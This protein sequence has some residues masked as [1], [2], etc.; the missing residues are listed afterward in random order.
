LLEINKTNKINEINAKLS[1]IPKMTLFKYLKYYL[2]NE[3]KKIE[4]EKE[5]KEIENNLGI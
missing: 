3:I 4:E 5:M 2:G 1:A